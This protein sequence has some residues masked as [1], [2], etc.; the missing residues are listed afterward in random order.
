MFL[1]FSSRIL[2]E[3][4]IFH[5][6]SVKFNP[7]SVQG[8]QVQLN[9]GSSALLTTHATMEGQ[10][11]QYLY[12]SCSSNYIFLLLTFSNYPKSKNFLFDLPFDPFIKYQL[13]Q[14]F[15]LI[16]YVRCACTH[17]Y[18][19][20]LF[21]LASSYSVCHNIGSGHLMRFRIGS[22][23]LILVTHYTIRRVVSVSVFV[24]Q[25]SVTCPCSTD[26]P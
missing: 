20:F 5:F 11:R 8:S 16:F 25:L 18:L 6:G 19:T 3:Y 15:V 2:M 26:N 12:Q 10:I 9:V 7:M 1:A 24:E 14:D 21:Y 4:Y 22:G 13:P 17:A 23:H